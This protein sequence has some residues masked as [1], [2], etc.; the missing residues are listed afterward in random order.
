MTNLVTVLGTILATKRDELAA[1]RAARSVADVDREARVA[2]P[3]RGL[4]RA[5]RGPPIRVLA[6][7]KRASPS[8]GTIRACTDADIPAI[9]ADYAGAG[10]AAI[11]VLT[12]RDYFAGDLAF[13]APVRAA[14]ALPLLRKDFLIDP[15]QVAAARA[16][17][18]DAVLLIVAA[19]DTPQLAEMLAAAR[20]YALDALVEVHD[21]SEAEV[22]ARVGA[23][24]VGVN[25]RDLRTFQ[26]DMSLTSRIAPLLP[27]GTIVVAESG[28]KTAAD[29]RGMRADA[30]L[31]GETLMRAADPATALRA[32]IASL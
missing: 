25:N 30:I 12:D 7:L 31:V 8:A 28:I 1:A 24:L 23:T 27:A 14:V 20:D 17:G 26:M 29:V 4:A 9:A 32:L 16:A 13:L 10:A 2:G 15:Y 5:L 11:S 21:A 6:E 18:A 3:V 19:L 22:A